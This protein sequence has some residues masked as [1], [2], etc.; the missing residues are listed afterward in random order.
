MASD[1]PLNLSSLTEKLSSESF[2]SSSAF[3]YY[4][5]KTRVG[6]LYQI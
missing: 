1:M 3:A 5:I 4:L 2:V 6:V